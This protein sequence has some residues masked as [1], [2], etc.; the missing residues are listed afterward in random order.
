MDNKYI[1]LFINTPI[2]KGLSK[3]AQEQ[4]K[5]AFS[6]I[7]ISKDKILFHQDDNIKNLYIL[8]RG[9][10]SIYH[11]DKHQD[12]EYE[13]ATLGE[14]E[15]VGEQTLFHDTD[16]SAAV[17]AASYCTLAMISQE[18][19]QKLTQDITKSPFWP[20]MLTIKK[21]RDVRLHNANEN[22]IK[23]LQEEIKRLAKNIGVISFLSSR[24]L[25]I[26]SVRKNIIQFFI[27]IVFGICVFSFLLEILTQLQATKGS[28]A[29]TIPLTFTLVFWAVYKAIKLN[30]QPKDLGF[31]LD[32]L[33]SALVEAVMKT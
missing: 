14:G 6:I 13:L 1:E 18:N 32:N 33:K 22:Q 20:M 26:L 24:M 8:L 31:R 29:V 12:H 4:A 28:S 7:H 19:F 9:K 3:D 11:E 10:V 23:Y 17:A 30:L 5:N 27:S 15:I 21:M 16:R 25:N 2:I